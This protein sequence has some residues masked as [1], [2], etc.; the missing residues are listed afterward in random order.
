VAGLHTRGKNYA[1][2]PW[3]IAKFTNG[4]FAP[5]A[6]E[7]AQDPEPLAEDFDYG[8]ALPLRRPIAFDPAKP[9]GLLITV[10]DCLPETL[11]L[12]L[13]S[14]RSMASLQVNVADT[15]EA[16]RSFDA[17]S[18]AD[19][20]RRAEIAGAPAASSLDE[21]SPDSL[22]AWARQSG[23]TQ[24]VT[25]YVPSGPTQDW[26]ERAKPALTD[27]GISLSEIRRDWDEA[28][29]PLATAGFFKVKK[30]IPR[31]I[32]DLYP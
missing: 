27:A 17:A 26:L 12:P 22:L 4:R 15:V 11:N 32:D 16:V 18:L 10:E 1:A 5:D 14:L 13:D 20:A 31:L 19:A 23:I 21:Q 8:E 6:R 24:I 25:A 2:A 29:W 30:K 7:L 9:S 28:V 3:N